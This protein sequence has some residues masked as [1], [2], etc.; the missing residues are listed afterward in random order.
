MNLKT[1]S[2]G[3]INLINLTTPKTSI[4]EIWE[5]KLES[6]DRNKLL[7][8][9]LHH[10]IPDFEIFEVSRSHFSEFEVS[11]VGRTQ[12]KLRSSTLKFSKS[13]ELRL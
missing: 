10:I 13:G 12:I 6:G 8:E 7:Q 3:V 11:D 1:P 4:L 2:L 9:G 5:I